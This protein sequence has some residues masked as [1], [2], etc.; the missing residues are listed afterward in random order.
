MILATIVVLT[1]LAIYSLTYIYWCPVGTDSFRGLQGRYLI[2]LGPLFFLLFY[3]RKMK[4]NLEHFSGL[5]VGGTVL[6]LS[7][8]LYVLAHRFYW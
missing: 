8:A 4:I 3:N 1:V 6:S 5:L 2:P 7:I